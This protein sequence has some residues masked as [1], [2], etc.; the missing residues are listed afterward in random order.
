VHLIPEALID[1]AK[2]RKSEKTEHQDFSPQQTSRQKAGNSRSLRLS[3]KVTACLQDR[4]Y[5][6]QYKV[7]AHTLVTQP[8]K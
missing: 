8:I 5:A 1:G 6:G 7:A 2:W 4:Q 3:P